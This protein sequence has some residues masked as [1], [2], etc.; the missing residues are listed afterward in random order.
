M[1]ARMAASTVRSK[2]SPSTEKMPSVMITSWNRAATAPA[3]NFHSKR[4]IT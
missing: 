3:E 1:T 2:S 4:N